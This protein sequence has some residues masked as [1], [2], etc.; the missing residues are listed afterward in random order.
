M[1]TDLLQY[2]ASTSY[3]GRGILLGKSPDGTCGVAAYFI[4]GRS[5][6]S[7][8]RVFEQ[9]DDG[10]R[11][12]AFDESK[13]EDPSLIIYNP[14]RRMDDGRLIVTNGDQ[15]DTI[16]S[17]F[18]AGWTFQQALAARTFE[19]DDPNW[20]PR[21]SG[22]LAP[23]GSCALSIIKPLNGDPACCC[24]FFFEYENPP[25]GTGQFLSTYE[26][27]G[28]PLPSFS[29]E[30]LTVSITQT[31]PEQLAAAVWEALDKDNRVSVYTAWINRETGQMDTYIINGKTA[32][33]E[34]E[35]SADE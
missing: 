28:S 19:P 26:K 20:T 31:G 30:P 5:A 25:A 27:D 9:T 4:M 8:N 15:T 2:L 29:G 14:V 13:M 22:L 21:I 35:K 7:R 24:R 16:R 1:K 12:K 23:D 17:A 33:E 32:K 10:I 6:N 11:T 3:P 34:E 18:L